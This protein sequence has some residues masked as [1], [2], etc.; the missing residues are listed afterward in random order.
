M[1]FG[2]LW[3][4]SPPPDFLPLGGTSASLRAYPSDESAT[5]WPPQP[6]IRSGII[7][8][9]AEGPAASVTNPGKI[10]TYADAIRNPCRISTSIFSALQVIWNE[11]L[12]KNGGGVVESICRDRASHNRVVKR[13]NARRE[14]GMANQELSGAN[15]V[16]TPL[17]RLRKQ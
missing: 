2:T 4:F 5:Q 11:H 13:Q 16:T 12:R 3:R 17:L 6:G 8:K 9:A 10:N 7:F 14:K 1:F 15:K